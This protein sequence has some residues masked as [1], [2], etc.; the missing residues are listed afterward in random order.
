M[1]VAGS[2]AGANAAMRADLRWSSRGRWPSA[3]CHLVSQ[4]IVSRAA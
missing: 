2:L 4:G 1:G 3:W